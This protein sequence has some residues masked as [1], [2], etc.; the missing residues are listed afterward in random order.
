MKNQQPEVNTLSQAMVRDH[1]NIER[2]LEQ[3]MAHPDR[4]TYNL[5]YW[6]L[7]KHIFTEEKAI[8][9][10]INTSNDN[11]QRQLD[12]TMREHEK[13]LKQ[14]KLV[15]ISSDDAIRSFRKVL[16][17]HKRWEDDRLYPM[18]DEMLSPQEILEIVERVTWGLDPSHE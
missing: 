17:T 13:L 1:S 10:H 9:T 7:E 14:A 6:N 8:F 18:L 11:I 2:L 16:I 4:R 15:D 5:F 3:W 12:R